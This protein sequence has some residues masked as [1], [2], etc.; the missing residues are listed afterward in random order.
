MALQV[1]AH[2]WFTAATVLVPVAYHGATLVQAHKAAALL[3][4]QWRHEY[5]LRSCGAVAAAR[6]N[7][8]DAAAILDQ[9]A[10]GSQYEI[11]A[12][13]LA[14]NLAK[15]RPSIPLANASGRCFDENNTA[16]GVRLHQQRNAAYEKRWPNWTF[17]FETRPP[18]QPSERRH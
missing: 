13:D 3:E 12:E 1:M 14:E 10:G 7:F 6:A 8:I 5:N 18:R 16:W 4:Q 2:S 11:L 15:E 9:L 17:V